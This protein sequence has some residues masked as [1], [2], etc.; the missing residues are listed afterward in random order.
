M[1][2]FVGCL[3]AGMVAVP[4]Y[5]PNPSRFER[6]LPRLRASAAD[7]GATMALTIRAVAALAAA[8]LSGAPHREPLRWLATDDIDIGGAA[9]WRDPEATPDTLAFLQYTSGSTASPRGVMVRHGNILHN[10]A[11]IH[12][13]AEHTPES[14]YVSWLPCYHDMGLIGG[15]L[16]PIYGG[17]LGVLM[18]PLAFL[19]RPLR[20]L[21]AITRHRGTTSPFPNFALDLGLQKITA[22]ERAAL[23]LSA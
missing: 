5:P 10:S 2:A 7:S 14:V 17:L 11:A 19:Q 16:Q 23:D 21:S 3:Y 18:S 4:A 6:E 9:D 20:W 22:P 15:I 1:C 12:R 8:A 13:L